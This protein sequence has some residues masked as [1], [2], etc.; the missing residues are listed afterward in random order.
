MTDT[1]SENGTTTEGPLSESTSQMAKKCL[2]IIEEFRRGSCTALDRVSVVGKIAE[3][4]TSATSELPESEVNVALGSYLNIVE[5]HI[6]NLDSDCDCGL[7]RIEPNNKP[8]TGDKHSGSLGTG[9]CTGKKPKIDDR[10]F[11]WVIHENLT[12]AGLSDDLHK[13]LRTYA[14]MPRTL[15]T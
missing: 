3:I 2:D 8:G 11:P 9:L 15:S 10:E 12:G 14:L 1:D 6:Q 13:L 5:Q 7:S 4:L